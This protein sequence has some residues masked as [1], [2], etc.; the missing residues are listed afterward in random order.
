MHSGRRTRRLHPDT[1][2]GWWVEQQAVAALELPNAGATEESTEE[3][4]LAVSTI[5]TRS[6]TS[7]RRVGAIVRPSGA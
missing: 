6:A 5:R 4:Y 1:M 2:N 3:W 7:S